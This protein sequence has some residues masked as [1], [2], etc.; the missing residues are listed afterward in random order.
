MIL[1]Q[2]IKIYLCEIIIWFS[3]KKNGMILTDDCVDDTSKKV[4]KKSNDFYCDEILHYNKHPFIHC[5]H[6]YN[7]NDLKE[8]YRYDLH[9][10]NRKSYTWTDETFLIVDNIFHALHWIHILFGCNNMNY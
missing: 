9:G 5:T 2:E 6:I 10:W 8:S 4:V 3:P 7:E 1:Y